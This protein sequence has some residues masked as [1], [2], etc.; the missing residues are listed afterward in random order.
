[1]VGS[2]QRS[3]R[4]NRTIRQHIQTNPM[5]CRRRRADLEA[6]RLAPFVR[7][8]PDGRV[9][10]ENAVAIE[11][12][13]SPQMIYTH[14]REQ[15]CRILFTMGRVAALGKNGYLGKSRIK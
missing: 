3:D 1:M 15:V 7:Q 4:T 10:N 8:L 9:E 13:N 2:I 6:Q 5:A 14:Y 11:A 12:G